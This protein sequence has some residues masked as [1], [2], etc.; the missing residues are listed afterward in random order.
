M[1]QQ[2]SQRI[3][4]LNPDGSSKQLNTDANGNLNVAV[5]GGLGQ[6]QLP[7]ALASDGSLKAS[8]TGLVW[9][10]SSTTYGP[11][12][13]GTALHS[14]LGANVSNPVAIN[15]PYNNM[16]I[17]FQENNTNP[18]Y[19]KIIGY[20]DAAL[21]VPIVLADGTASAVNEQVAKNAS[22]YESCSMALMGIDVQVVAQN[23]DGSHNG[24]STV[25]IVFA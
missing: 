19:V 21:T 20:L 2:V 14:V 25:I 22:N 12:V 4:L 10:P 3:V 6:A 11:A 9:K 13:A 16:T 5:P 1:S 8:D 24:S 23:T 7:S 15:R 17:Y 18:I